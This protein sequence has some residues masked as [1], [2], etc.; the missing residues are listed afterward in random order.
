MAS[1]RGSVSLHLASLTGPS[2]KVFCF[3]PVPHLFRRLQMNTQH[4]RHP[5]VLDIQQ[6]ALSDADGK[7]VF[8]IA[9]A[10]ACNQGM[11]S[12]V[13]DDHPE[14]S[15]FVE[16]TT[17][18]LSEFCRIEKVSRI[19]F[20][21]MDVQGAEPF[22]LLGG[23]DLSRHKPDL[24][25]RFHHMTLASVAGQAGTSCRCSK[26]LITAASHCLKMGARVLRL[27]Q[28]QS[29]QI[30]GGRMSIAP[31]KRKLAIFDKISLCP[32]LKRHAVLFSGS[33]VRWS[34]AQDPCIERRSA[35]TEAFRQLLTLQE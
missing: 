30:T 7:S 13:N 1:L 32:Y 15:S 17:T 19:D 18:T 33:K 29:R 8:H 26:I 6:L 16:V 31:R 10:S 28:T 11:G 24:R 5:A 27:P 35:S 25:L 22:V 12:L 21:K 34:A 9:K 14:L 20:I 4:S 23:R 2:G 3:E